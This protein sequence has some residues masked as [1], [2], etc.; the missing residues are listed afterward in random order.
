MVGQ[1]RGVSPRDGVVS[2]VPVDDRSRATGERLGGPGSVGRHTCRWERPPVSRTC[3]PEAPHMHITAT[4][5]IITLLAL[6]AILAVDLLIVGRRP[7]E[8]SMK[9]SAIW[10]AGYV[11]LAVI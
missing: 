5:W 10:V 3:P 4:T 9:E 1:W 6:V 8:P 2:T 7:H 11:G